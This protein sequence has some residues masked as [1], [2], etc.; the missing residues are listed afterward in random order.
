MSP[1]VQDVQDA[2]DQPPLLPDFLIVK[3]EDRA[4]ALCIFE[5]EIGTSI[6]DSTV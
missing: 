1:P 6:T 2:V 4:A 3:K 5:L